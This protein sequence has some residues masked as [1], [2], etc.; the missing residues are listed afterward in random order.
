VGLLDR[1]KALF[2][3]AP[4]AAGRDESPAERAAEVTGTTGGMGA[5]FHGADSDRRDD[6]FE[7][8]VPPDKS[9]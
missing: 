9:D 8:Q 3:N 7:P 6:L 1:L 4:A 2:G 5:V